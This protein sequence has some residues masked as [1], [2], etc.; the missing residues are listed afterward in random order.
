MG[1]YFFKKRGRKRNCHKKKSIL[2]VKKNNVPEES[3][4]YDKPTD[5]AAVKV[6]TS[7]LDKRGVQQHKCRINW[8]SPNY[9]PILV[10]TVLSKQNFCKRFTVD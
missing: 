2:F 6:N 10:K 4:V 1:D 9:F 5:F 3:I 7:K 8:Q